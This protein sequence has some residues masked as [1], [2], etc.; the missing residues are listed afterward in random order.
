MELYLDVFILEN[1]VLNILVIFISSKLLGITVKFYRIIL[2]AISG[3]TFAT[4]V[5]IIDRTALNSIP[6]KIIIS[7]ALVF[8]VFYPI[9]FV[10]FFKAFAI[11]C[12]SAIIVA[13]TMFFIANSMGSSFYIFNG[14]FVVQAGYSPWLIVFG[15]MLSM[16]FVKILY[17]IKRTIETSRKQLISICVCIDDK[18]ITFP[19]LLDTGNLLKDPLT[20]QPVIIAEYMA[21]KKILPEEM[22]VFIDSTKSFDINRINS[23]FYD[24]GWFKRLRLI[25]FSSIGNDNG[26]LIGFRPDMVQIG[27]S[28]KI[29]TDVII[30]IYQRSLSRN[31]EF[32]A[33]LGPQLI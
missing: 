27:E 5:L 21:L 8:I 17:R 25:P 14:V 18:K 1:T 4:L 32:Q 30:G 10:D 19:A 33:L 6:L 28:K 2:G 20:G 11:F 16:G 12:L 23:A 24:T 22:I 9:C 13:G 29:A 15:I 3:T 7:G 31:N 26:V